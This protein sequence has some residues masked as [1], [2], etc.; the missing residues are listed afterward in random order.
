MSSD[1][2]ADGEY[3]VRHLNTLLQNKGLISLDKEW[4]VFENLSS[5]NDD[6]SLTDQ[7]LDV[8]PRRSVS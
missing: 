5:D 7:L 6:R 4:P 1:S 3:I 2:S 8:N